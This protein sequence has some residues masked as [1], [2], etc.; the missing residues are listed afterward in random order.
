MSALA[1]RAQPMSVSDD[2][3]RALLAERIESA[4]ASE[5]RNMLQSTGLSRGEM[6]RMEIFERVSPS[7]AFIS[8]AIVQPGSGG[9]AT[10]PVGAGSGFIWDE[11]GHVVTNFHVIN[12]GPVGRR[13][14]AIPKKV[15]VKLQG[16]EAA[17]EARVVGHEA[18]KDIAVLKL[19][20]VALPGPLTPVELAS[21]ADLRVG[22]SV[23]A[24]GAP[25]G[26]D[27]TLTS[28]IVSAVGRDID[29]AGGRPIRDCVQTD[30]AINPGN[31]GGPLLDSRGRV[32]GVNTMI[33]APGGLGQVGIGFAV[34]SDTLRLFVNR[35]I[36]HG[37]N[38]K[39]SLGVSVLPDQ[40][41]AEYARSL[42]RELEGALI[43][44]VV[45][46]S[47][48]EALDLAP[49][50]PAEQPRAA[51]PPSSSWSTWWPLGRQAAAEGPTLL[52]GDMITAVDGKPVRKNEDLLCAVEEAEPDEALRITVMRGCDPARVEEVLITPVPRQALMSAAA[53]E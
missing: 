19:D 48:A 17:V 38:S 25:F 43:A 6:S 37:P 36:T 12:G 8:T 1:A 22:Q 24:I 42:R 34:P 2:E 20:P 31:S 29:G 35:I 23:L 9:A 50:R 11:D 45:K 53:E 30:A 33:Y 15:M 7:V 27:W 4:D 18:S 26:L 5:L 16:Q 28:G 51:A 47:P 3:L 32:L 46:G 10:I 52:L 41:R 49:C 44:E 21:S 39:P 13:G 14:S 40:L